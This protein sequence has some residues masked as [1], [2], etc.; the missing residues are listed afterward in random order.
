MSVAPEDF[1]MEEEEEDTVFIK[2]EKT[3]KRA[4]AVPAAYT[5]VEGKG[6]CAA[7]VR[8]GEPCQVNAEVLARCYEDAKAGKILKATPAGAVCW[9]CKL[10]RKKCELPAAQ[11]LVKGKAVAKAAPSPRVSSRRAESTTP[12]AA[13]GSKRKRGL[14]MSVELPPMKK[15]KVVESEDGVQQ[16]LLTLLKRTDGRLVEAMGEMRRLNETQMKVA[17]ALALAAESQAKDSRVVTA[18]LACLT[19]HVAPEMAEEVALASPSVQVAGVSSEEAEV[20]GKSGEEDEE[21]AEEAE[22]VEGAE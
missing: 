10:K 1:P 7:C 6:R 14:V 4:V 20:E 22:E 13:S 11:A 21:E 9:R 18:L 2:Q 5:I 3:P 15:N 16:A 12:S 19:R 17:E 8:D